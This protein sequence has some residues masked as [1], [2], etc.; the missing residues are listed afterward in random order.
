[1]FRQWQ[2]LKPPR[3]IQAGKSPLLHD[4]Q[5]SNHEKA[6]QRI[7]AG[8]TDLKRTNTIVGGLRMDYFITP[9]GETHAGLIGGPGIY[10]AV[11]ARIWSNDVGLISRVGAGYPAEWL[12]K[13]ERHGIDVSLVKMLPEPIEMRHFFAYHERERVI[14]SNPATF[15]LQAGTTMPKE[16]VG[17]QA[18]TSTASIKETYSP[19]SVRPTDLPDPPAGI[20][21]A[22]ICPANYL[23]HSTLPLRLRELGAEIITLD[24]SG[25]YMHA[26]YRNDLPLLV[27]GLDAFLLNEREA[28]A[29]FEP[30]TPDLPEMAQAFCDMGCRYVVF[31]RGLRGQLVYDGSNQR[32]WEIPAYNSR[33]KDITGAG[34]AYCGGFNVGLEQ[35]N[36]ILQAALYGTTSASLTV[37]GTGALFALGALPGLA[38][39]RLD[40]LRALVKPI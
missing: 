2:S 33:V 5:V 6:R 26:A 32:G 17:Y 28:R 18:P 16:L 36:D 9:D 13:F 39:A 19:L 8:M 21:S 15:F 4:D 7:I 10:A 40:A 37:E 20:L 1:M 31:K 29:V 12:K 30:A 25:E 35:T 11:G 38:S 27:N 14:Q 23:T 34:D 24:P 22:H 3:L